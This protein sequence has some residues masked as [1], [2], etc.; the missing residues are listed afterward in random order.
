MEI[1][2]NYEAQNQKTSTLKDGSGKEN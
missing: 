1:K 2:E